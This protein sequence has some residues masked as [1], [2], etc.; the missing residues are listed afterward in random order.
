MATGTIKNNEWQLVW[1]NP[2]ITS[3]QAEQTISTLNLTPYRELRLI[4]VRNTGQ[5][6]TNSLVGDYSIDLT[7]PALGGVICFSGY[8]GSGHLGRRIVDTFSST[9]FRI[10]G[11][12]KYASYGTAS[13]DNT[14]LPLYKVFAR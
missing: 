6:T 13:S 5:S 3:A 9:G 4:F 8:D 1:E 7:D 11:A 14:I 12:Q 2:N 10:Q